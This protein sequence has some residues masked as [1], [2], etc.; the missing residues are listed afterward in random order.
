MLAWNQTVKD[1]DRKQ[2][3]RPPCMMDKY[4]CLCEDI[5]QP[6]NGTVQAVK[7]ITR[8]SSKGFERRQ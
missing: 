2:L 6:L 1:N 4:G 3:D 8:Y 5:A 7:I